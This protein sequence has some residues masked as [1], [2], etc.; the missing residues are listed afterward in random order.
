MTADIQGFTAAASAPGILQEGTE[1]AVRMDYSQE[2]QYCTLYYIFWFVLVGLV[3]FLSQPCRT[4][5]TPA[6]APILLLL[7]SSGSLIMTVTLCQGRNLVADLMSKYGMGSR[8][9]FGS[10]H[11]MDA[12]HRCGYSGGS[13][14]L[15]TFLTP[16]PRRGVCSM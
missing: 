6:P 14:L 12:L 11:K 13:G 3:M 8:D 16:G 1:Q 7:P 15:L 5:V 4:L 2:V 10:Y 9:L